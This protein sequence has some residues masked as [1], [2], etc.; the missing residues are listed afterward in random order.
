MA[1]ISSQHTSGRWPSRRRLGRRVTGARPG[2]APRPA[3]TRARTGTPRRAA[4]STSTAWADAGSTTQGVHRALGAAVLVARRRGSDV[5]TPKRRSRCCTAADQRARSGPRT[6]TLGLAARPAPG[7]WPRAGARG[8][9]AAA[10]GAG[11]MM[12]GGSAT[13]AVV[14]VE[15]AVPAQQGQAVEV[16]RPAALHRLVAPRAPRVP[17][18]PPSPR[19]WASSSSSPPAS[20]WWPKYGSRAATAMRSPR[21]SSASGRQPVVGEERVGGAWCA[22][23]RPR[24]VRDL[25]D[26]LHA[27][28]DE[29]RRRGDL[30]PA[31]ARSRDTT[32][33]HSPADPAPVQLGGGDQL[34]GG[35]VEDSVSQATHLPID[36]PGAD[37][38]QRGG[39][40]ARSSSSRSVKPVGV[41]VTAM[42][43]S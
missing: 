32:C 22:R 19:K 40:Q 37:D 16:H 24:R 31:V 2:A 18:S 29:R 38:V 27:V 12:A 33:T 42:P 25:E 1:T 30:E 5:T 6:T 39:L 23:T 28:V 4:A 8:T 9:A 10:R 34:A 14:G 17:R 3:A 15:Q 20:G 13:R 35:R 26:R 11:G 7:G 36:G 41:P 21:R 43:C